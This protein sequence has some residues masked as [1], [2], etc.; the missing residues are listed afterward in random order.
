MSLAA[1]AGAQTPEELH[2]AA[3]ALRLDLSVPLMLALG[4]FEFSAWQRL[5][6]QRTLGPSA[7]VGEMLSLHRDKRAMVDA[8][9]AGTEAAGRWSAADLLG[10]LGQGAE[11]LGAAP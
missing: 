1:L 2:A 5:K 4:Q 11:R 3:V 9:L 6:L 8:L 10:L 7:T